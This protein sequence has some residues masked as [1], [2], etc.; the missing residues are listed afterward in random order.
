MRLLTIFYRLIAPLQNNHVRHKQPNQIVQISLRHIKDAHETN[1]ILRY[2][3]L[4]FNQLFKKEMKCLN[5]EFIVL[6]RVQANS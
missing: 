1:K 3:L 5:D 4:T 6:T 2:N